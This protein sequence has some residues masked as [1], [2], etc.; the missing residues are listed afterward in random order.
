MSKVY[1]NIELFHVHIP[2]TAGTSL[3]GMLALSF[4]EQFSEHTVL[5]ENK[6]IVSAA[7]HTVLRSAKKI[8]ELAI[9]IPA[10]YVHG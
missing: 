1:P 4:D 7:S 2:K 3:N 10:E 8:F 9:F 5:E 6:N